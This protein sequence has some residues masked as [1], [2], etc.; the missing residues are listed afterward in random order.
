MTRVQKLKQ[1]LNQNM[2]VSCLK[3]YNTW[4]KQIIKQKQGGYGYV[5]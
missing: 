1:F 2:I 5:K 4:Y 3:L